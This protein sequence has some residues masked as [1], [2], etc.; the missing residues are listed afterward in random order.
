[1]SHMAISVDGIINGL[2]CGCV[3]I[4]LMSGSSY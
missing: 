2:N 3:F 4:L 1:M